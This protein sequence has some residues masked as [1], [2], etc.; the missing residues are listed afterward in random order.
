MSTGESGKSVTIFF[1]TNSKLN[2]YLGPKDHTVWES[3]TNLR[4]VS[5]SLG[6]FV[7]RCI[8]WMKD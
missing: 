3:S 2:P 4:S 5:P 7:K 6:I 8:N 1:S